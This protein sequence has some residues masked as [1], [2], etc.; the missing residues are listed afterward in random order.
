M[1]HVR[2]CLPPTAA[3]IL[4][5]SAATLVGARQAPARKSDERA[6]QIVDQ[7]LTALGGL[8]NYHATRFIRF[9]FIRVEQPPLGITWDKYTGRYR[10]DATTKDAKPS[11]VLMNVNTKEG[12]VFVAGAPVE[13]KERGDYLQQAL[14]IWAGEIYWFLAP[15]KLK[16]QG[17]ILRYDGEETIDGTTYDRI[18]VTYE[19]VGLT[20]GDQF[21]DY[22]NRKTHLMDRWRF[23]LKGGAKGDFWW[24]NWQKY[25]PLMLSPTRESVDR[26]VTIRME[27]IVVTNT[28]PDSVFES[29]EPVKMP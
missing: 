14:R 22:I 9:T 26:K 2:V 20:P 7:M 28:M 1:R 25:G 17:V 29:P 11:V 24:R 8:D 12:R 23:A 5:L 18:H 10:L 6:V 4:V 19:N 21:W 16:D 3:A 15:Y 27:D 13:G